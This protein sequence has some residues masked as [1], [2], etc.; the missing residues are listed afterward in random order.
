MTTPQSLSSAKPP[1]FQDE[2]EDLSIDYPSGDG[3]PM[4]E[5]DWQ[6]DAIA[7]T[8]AALRNRYR[9]RTDIY[10]A[11]D[12]LVYYRMNDNASRVA[13]D[14]YVV[15]GKA[16]DF[17]LEVASPGT[18]EADAGRKRDV[19]A[20]MGV[21]EYWRFD[22]RS[23]FFVPELIGE[24]LQ[25]GEYRPLP[26]HTDADGILRGNSAI[27]SLDICVRPGP[28]LRFYDPDAGEWL[29][30]PAENYAAQRETE[31]A[32]RATE[33]ARM[34]AEVARREAEDEN[35]RLREQLRLLQSGQ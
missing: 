22:P 18:W 4:A 6:W 17:V 21:T 14:V 8:V 23:E 13:P 24:Q 11:G 7:D 16:P 2:E 12:M 29:L 15:E 19:Y 20:A 26:L 1:L 27:L 10:V 5:N 31:A 32:L 34:S 30:A 33:A 25:D 28:E 9:E 35:R 3:E